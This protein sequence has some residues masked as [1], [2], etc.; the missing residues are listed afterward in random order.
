M[1]SFLLKIEKA[2]KAFSYRSLLDLIFLLLF[3]LDIK[4][5]V[6]HG[7]GCNEIEKY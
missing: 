7:R 2:W 6:L 4:M 1:K 5:V 3:M